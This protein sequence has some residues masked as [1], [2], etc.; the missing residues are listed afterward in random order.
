MQCFAVPENAH[1]SPC[2]HHETTVLKVVGDI[3]IGNRL[4]KGGIR[5]K[6]GSEI[7]IWLTKLYER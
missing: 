6:L 3:S 7:G 4:V 5:E 2:I 1:I